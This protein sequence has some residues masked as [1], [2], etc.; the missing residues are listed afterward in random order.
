MSN[1]FTPRRFD[2]RDD[3]EGYLMIDARALILDLPDEVR[4]ATTRPPMRGAAARFATPA[5]PGDGVMRGAFRVP[6]QPLARDG[7]AG[8]TVWTRMGRKLQQL[9]RMHARDRE[10]RDGRW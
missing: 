5:R 3:D 9:W 2:D 10:G 8:A 7:G 4:A 1:A 6:L